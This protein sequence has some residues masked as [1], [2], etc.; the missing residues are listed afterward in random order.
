M[1]I[2]L[3]GAAPKDDDA[4]GLSELLIDAVDHPKRPHV[5]I[6]VVDTGKVTVDTDTD[7]STPTLRIRR[8]EVVPEEH[9]EHAYAMFEAA[10]AERTGQETLPF[11]AVKEIRDG[12]GQKVN[13][14]TGEVTDIASRRRRRK[15]RTDS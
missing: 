15:P 13:A 10:Y 14:T 2:K 6:A 12:L 9:R 1:P 5:I 8:V 7:A 3:S 11:P 4:N